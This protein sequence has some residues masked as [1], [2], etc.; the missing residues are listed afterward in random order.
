MLIY[1]ALR[2]SGKVPRVHGNGFLQLDLNDEGTK[3]LHIWDD[4]LPSQSVKSSI[5]DHVFE[6]KSTILC[7][8]LTHIEYET[9]SPA[10]NPQ[11]SYIVYRAEQVPG[12]NN[13][14]LKPEKEIVSLQETRRFTFAPGSTYNFPPYE[15]HDTQHQGF[16]A[17][18][19]NKVKA[20]KDYGRPRVLVPFP[21][22]PDNDFDREGFD[23][24]TLW[25]FVKRV[26][27]LS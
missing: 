24:E 7:G 23:P 16:T 10:V 20:P 1:E 4:K 2:D 27:D 8:R 9:V 21:E 18:I 19:M 11:D 12:S 26:C 22:S 17:T 13:T 6:L 25:P 5:H 14:V 3:R 15:L